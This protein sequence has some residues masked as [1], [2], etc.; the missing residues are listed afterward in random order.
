MGIWLT[1][2]L[3]T[4]ADLNRVEENP[5]ATRRDSNGQ[6]GLHAESHRPPPLRQ[7]VPDHGERDGKCAGL[8]R[9]HQP[10]AGEH[11]DSMPSQRLERVV[12]FSTV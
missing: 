3:V 5:G 12:N 4:V 7:C 8:P 6:N 1:P 10:E 2:I 11:H 9:Y